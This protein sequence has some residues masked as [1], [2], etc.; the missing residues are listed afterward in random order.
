MRFHWFCVLV[1]LVMFSTAAYAAPKG[2]PSAYQCGPGTP[3]VGIG[4]SCP[5][6]HAQ[7]RDAENAAT[8][9]A[10]PKVDAGATTKFM[11]AL[12]DEDIEAAKEL[13][14]KIDGAADK[15]AVDALTTAF[16]VWMHSAMVGKVEK[17]AELGFCGLIQSTLG[18]GW[19]Y[20]ET[21]GNLMKQS[22]KR[23]PSLDLVELVRSDADGKL[24]PI[25]AAR[26]ACIAAASKVDG[27]KQVESALANRTPLETCLKAQKSVSERDFTFRLVID[28][29]G[30]LVKKS[31]PNLP[32]RSPVMTDSCLE[33]FLRDAKY[34]KSPRGYAG[35]FAITIEKEGTDR[36][37][38]GSA[39]VDTLGLFVAQRDSASGVMVSEVVPNSLAAKAGLQVRDRILKDKVTG[40]AFNK[41]FELADTAKPRTTL[42]LEYERERKT[43]T[44]TIVI[45]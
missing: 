41:P 3:V 26:D 37:M 39:R 31:V 14:L 29:N 11:K 16:D 23:T 9:V 32:P 30:T 44:V 15:K 4:C 19:D 28:A 34:P 24:S 40:R 1:V 6:T 2:V 18:Y 22:Q 38:R 45:P 25:Y 35:T 21:W 42:E 10:I 17:Q 27:S 20:V 7:R 13:A 36:W 33:E 43:L 5:A 8:C 12:N